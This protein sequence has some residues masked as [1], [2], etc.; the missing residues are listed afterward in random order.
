MA[1][2]VIL[3]GAAWGQGTGAKAATAPAANAAAMPAFTQAELFKTIQTEDAELFAAYNNCDLAKMSQ[4]VAEDLEFYH[5]KTGLMTGRQALVDAV[6]NNICGK[7][8]REL[9]VGS[10]EVYP[11]AG[12]GA[13]E[14]GTHRFTHPGKDDDLGEAKFVH[15]WR[16]KDG[17]W[18]V[19]RVISFDHEGVKK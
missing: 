14:I 2:V 5:D 11:I 17:Q 4:M 12:Y 16:Y 1:A 13:V 6:K 10:L 18:Q 7:V 15:L 19:T 9:V 3:T 8:H